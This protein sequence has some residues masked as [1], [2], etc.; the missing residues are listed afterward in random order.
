MGENEAYVQT[1]IKKTYEK[2]RDDVMSILQKNT[3]T[4]AINPPLGPLEFEEEKDWEKIKDGLMDYYIGI[5][6]ITQKVGK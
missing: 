3:K 1:I 5:E 6:K 2:V 4:I